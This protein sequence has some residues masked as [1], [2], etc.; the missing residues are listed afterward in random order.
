MTLDISAAFDTI[1]HILLL[2]CL[3]RIGISGIPL[4]WFQSYLSKRKIKLK[5]KN[6]FSDIIDLLIGIPQG[7]VL[8]PTLYSIYISDIIHL[9]DML[10]IHYH[11]YADDIIIY[12]STK[13]FKT[14]QDLQD[15]INALMIAI[16]NFLISK[17]L[18][19]NSDKTEIMHISHNSRL[20]LKFNSIDILNENIKM[21]STIKCIG[22]IIDHQLNMKQQI[23]ETIKKSN[24]ALH[25][26]SKIRQ[27]LD[28]HSTQIIINALVISKLEYNLELLYNIKQMDVER[29]EKILR[30]SI[31]LI[32]NLKKKDSV[33]A[34]MKKI[35]WL[36]IAER[37]KI[38]N[39][40][41]IHNSL[42]CQEPQYI[43]DLF[44]MN[45][46]PHTRQN[47]GSNLK[48][49]LAL[50]EFHKKALSIYGPSLYNQIPLDIRKSNN[51]ND[52]LKK[53]YIKKNFENQ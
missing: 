44:E 49:P 26:V 5:L 45:E 30:K 23:S 16:K 18:K 12:F 9:L 21:K 7:G 50:S 31:R 24:F 34:Y 51:F 47:N 35:N 53:Y 48:I 11:L 4:K 6:N 32:F 3:K 40:K 38:K 2:D 27:F 41:I 22:Y 19:L 42:C 20:N 28:I 43:R 25:C 52:R 8:S 14:V 37:I 29:L 36:P 1:I 13:N 17:H 46:N 15:K 10:D 39:I 33:T